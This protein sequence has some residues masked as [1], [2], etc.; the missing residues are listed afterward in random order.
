MAE[1]IRDSLADGSRPDGEA[2]DVILLSA[3]DGPAT[4]RLAQPV[5]SDTVTAAGRPWA[6][7]LGQRYTQLDKL[8]S[9]VT[10]TSQL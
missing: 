8:S 7:T 10:R 3:P 6:W 2:C 5:K 9:G 4:V 1:V